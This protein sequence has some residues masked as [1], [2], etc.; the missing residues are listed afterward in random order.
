MQRSRLQGEFVALLQMIPQLVRSV[1]G[2]AAIHN[3]ALERV[4]FMLLHVASVVTAAAE[5]L[6]AAFG[7]GVTFLASSLGW[8]DD[9]RLG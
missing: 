9:R 3:A 8:I 1:E 2:L 5:G 7:A 6:V 4:E